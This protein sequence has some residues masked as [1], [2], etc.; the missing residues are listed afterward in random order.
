MRSVAFARSVVVLPSGDVGAPVKLQLEREKRRMTRDE[1]AAM[2]G[3]KKNYLRHIE[4]GTPP[5]KE[6]KAAIRRAL[7]RC[8]V[9]RDFGIKCEHKLPVPSDEVLYSPIEIAQ[10]A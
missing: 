2:C 1:L 5:S 10:K 9:H 6:T 7:E 4:T 8:P 3:I